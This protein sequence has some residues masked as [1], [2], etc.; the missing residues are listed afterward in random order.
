MKCNILMAMAID[1]DIVWNSIRYPVSN[2]SSKC[3]AIEDLMHF[4]DIIN[5]S[6]I[7]RLCDLLFIQ[8]AD[9]LFLT[10]TAPS[11]FAGNS[12]GIRT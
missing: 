9:S 4:V 12:T 11:F 6:G 5:I 2:Q 7:L 10:L 8:E 1:V 3:I